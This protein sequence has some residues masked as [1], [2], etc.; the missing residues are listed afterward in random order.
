VDNL[1]HNFFRIADD[2]VTIF[3]NSGFFSNCSVTLHAI[4][5]YF[6]ETGEFPNNVDFSQ[7]FCNFKEEGRLEQDV[8][9]Q[10][11]FFQNQ[12]RATL[13][14]PVI[15][16]LY[17]LLDYREQ[18]YRAIK[19]FID[20]YFKPSEAVLT[21]AE[22]L[23]QRYK[24]DL[25]RIITI[26]Y[27]GTDKHKDTRLGSFET[28]ID[29]ARRVLEKEPGLDVLVQTDQEQ[30]LDYAREQLGSVI[31][32]DELPRTTT[33]TV[34]HKVVQG[35]KLAWA[36]TFL[37]AI[38]LLSNSRHLVLHTGNVARWMCL[39]RGHTTR[40]TQY[41]HPKDADCGYWIRP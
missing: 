19:P 14:S 15:F 36:Q 31:V 41:F 40:V 22:N 7:T 10:Y 17:S 6:N 18:S 4:T 37:A 27:R 32:F 13:N 5:K 28:F 24:L 34:M 26:C 12:I 21:K 33:D 11:F 8:Y 2:R 25:D 3:H 9:N 1:Q 16:P 29:E 30:F 23:C 35:G 38:Y 20:R 39:Y